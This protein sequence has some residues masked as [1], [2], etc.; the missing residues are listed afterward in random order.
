MAV[1]WDAPR[2]DFAALVEH[3]SRE[4]LR[5]L[6]YNVGAE[7]MTVGMRLWQLAPGTCAVRRGTVVRQEGAAVRCRWAPDEERRH[8]CRGWAHPFELP[9]RTEEIIDFR[10]LVRDPLP[11]ALP[12]LALSPADVAR[13]PDGG[14]VVAVHNL[15]TEGAPPAAVALEDASGRTI[16]ETRTGPVPGTSEFLPSTVTVRLAPSARGA[17]AR[18]V[19]DPGDEIIELCE[20]NNEA[21]VR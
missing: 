2:P 1:T 3:A 21:A 12:D 11:D 17:G 13:G 6:V 8:R 4:H 10:L 19:L 14:L 9:S 7:P 15:S 5:V 16:A 18:V 20:F